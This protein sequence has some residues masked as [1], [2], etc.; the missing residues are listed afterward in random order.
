MNLMHEPHLLHV[1]FYLIFYY[2]FTSYFGIDGVD[3][4]GQWPQ[5]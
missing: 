2:A 4:L 3:L 5:R 1:E